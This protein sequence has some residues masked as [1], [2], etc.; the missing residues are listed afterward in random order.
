VI[1]SV[2]GHPLRSDAPRH[3][4]LAE[5]HPIRP[6]SQGDHPGDMPAAEGRPA[7]HGQGPRLRRMSIDER[8]GDL[9]AA[10]L[11]GRLASFGSHR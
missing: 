11:S 2:G 5:A 4:V 8:L 6:A 3:V 10:C 1:A 7:H 9:E